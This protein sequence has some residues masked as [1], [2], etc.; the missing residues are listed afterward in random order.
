MPQE[1][2][3]IVY[4]SQGPLGAEVAKSKLE[5]EGIPAMLRYEAVGRVLG[6]TVDGLGRVEVLVRPQDEAAARQILEEA[7]LGEEPPQED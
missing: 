7:P 2:F 1:E 3:V 6:L 5:A 4:V